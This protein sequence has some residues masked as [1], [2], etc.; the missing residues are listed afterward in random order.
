M[1]MYR[2]E[3]ERSASP[4]GSPEKL[5]E[6]ICKGLPAYYKSALRTLKRAKKQ[7]AK[8]ENPR[9]S[10]ADLNN[11]FGHS[12]PSGAIPLSRAAELPSLT[13]RF[14]LPLPSQSA[15]KPPLMAGARLPCRR[16]HP[17]LVARPAPSAPARWPRAASAE[18]AAQLLGGRSESRLPRHRHPTARC[19]NGPPTA[20]RPLTDPTSR[21]R[22]AA[23]AAAALG[24]DGE[25]QHSWYV[26]RLVD[27]FFL[28]TSPRERQPGPTAT[29][30]APPH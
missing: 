5:V 1:K 18:T 19:P 10:N 11:M 21:R 4:F 20:N 9:M 26:G 22:G 6:L 7:D 14:V 28:I 3:A 25:Q 17:R 12:L 23:A 8:I 29:Q 13:T 2:T 16:R 27:S 30:D 24:G 15:P